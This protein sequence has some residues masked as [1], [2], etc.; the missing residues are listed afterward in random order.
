MHPIQTLHSINNQVKESR[1][2]K[3]LQNVYAAENIDRIT[4]PDEICK[5]EP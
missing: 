5:I 4:K 1:F 3:K 2:I